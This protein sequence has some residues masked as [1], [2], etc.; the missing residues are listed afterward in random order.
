MSINMTEAFGCTITS[1]FHLYATCVNG[2]NGTYTCLCPPG[3]SGRRCSQ[4]NNF[5][6]LNYEY[7]NF[8][9]LNELNN[10]NLK[11]SLNLC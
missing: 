9:L 1:C 4:G 6:S 5:K 10:I 3:W 11:I 7:I 2:F 8:Q